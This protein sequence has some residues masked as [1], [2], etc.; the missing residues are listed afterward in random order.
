MVHNVALHNI[1]VMTKKEKSKTVSTKHDSELNYRSP[2]SKCTIL[3]KVLSIIQ[4]Q[5]L[6]LKVRTLYK[7]CM[8]VLYK[9]FIIAFQVY[10]TDNFVK[11]GTVM[12]I[13][14][15]ACFDNHLGI[16]G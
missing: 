11:C 6:Y 14:G 7:K 10:S 4:K 2:H 15:P 3:R 1:T 9:K 5:Y 16:F 12:R 13:V 8:N